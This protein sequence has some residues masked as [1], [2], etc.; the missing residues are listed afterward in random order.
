MRKFGWDGK[1]VYLTSSQEFAI[2]AFRVRAHDYLLK[3]M[4][5]AQIWQTLDRSRAELAA[6]KDRA[7]LV[8]T[9]EDT[10]KLFLKDI[11]YA[12][13]SRRNVV[14]HMADSSQ[15][16]SLSIRTSFC[17]AVKELTTDRRFNLCGTSLSLNMDH[18]TM[19]DKDSVR[20]NS[21]NVCYLS[22]K[23]CLELRSA[24]YDH[25]FDEGGAS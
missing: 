18:I 25:H 13:L 22:K 9:K 1:I 14:Y 5:K 8:R 16:V 23:A 24:W 6:Y 10:R 7:I 20:F 15:V 11:E 3:P 21:G 2:D 19:V 4:D 12:E 17:E